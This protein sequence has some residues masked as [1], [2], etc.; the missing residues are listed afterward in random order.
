MRFAQGSLKKIFPFAGSLLSGILLVLCFP[1]YDFGWLAWTALVPLLIAISRSGPAYGFGLAFLCGAVFFPGIFDW[2]LGIEGYRAYHHV[3][4]GVY[5]SSYLGLFGLGFCVISKG[6]GLRPALFS[7]PFLW[8][9]L[10]LLRSSL[11]FMSLPWGFLGHSQY[12]YQR[13]IQ[14][15][16]FTGAYGVSF[17]VVLVNGA[18]AGTLESVSPMV[19]E[20]NPEAVKDHPMKGGIFL[21]VVAVILSGVALLYGYSVVP[22]KIIRQ[23]ITVS[24][25]QGDIPQNKKWDPQNAKWIMERYAGLSRE[26]SRERP[27]LI[28]WPE[29]ATP[30]YVLKNL[31][32]LHNL[33]LLIQDIKTYFLIG[34]SEYPKFTQNPIDPT[35]GGNTALLFSPTG[36]VVGQYIKIHLVPFYERIPYEGIVTW[37]K[38]IV[39]EGR[40]TYT[41]PGKDIT[42][43]RL[44]DM[45][46]FGVLIC[47]ES[48]FPDL[49][50][51]LVKNGAS[52]IANISNEAMFGKTEFPYQFL[53]INVMRAVENRIS[54][55]RAGNTGISCFIDPY[56]RIY[57]RLEKNG[58]DIFVEGYLTDQVFL[59]HDKTFY[60][61]Y[62]DVFAY[63]CVTVSFLMLIVAIVKKRRESSIIHDFS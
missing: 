31:G 27:K 23:G 45:S 47:W 35:K 56:G 32:L 7:A 19:K 15:S 26:A 21:A 1:K 37:P 10:E 55:V 49:F 42:L 30:G 57:A 50:R 58:R 33:T 43:F 25:I 12:E 22:K 9:S 62:G 61:N 44:D 63:L 13:I 53:A 41:L 54:I 20:S 34:S 14:V 29:T 3:I 24:V 38:F 17:L 52:F 18:I 40:K 60:T 2:I 51:R 36:Q 6:L 5:L 4:L 46:A 59:S 39:P 28:I 8:V 11:S 16:S 48:L